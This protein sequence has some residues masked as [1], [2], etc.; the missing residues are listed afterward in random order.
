MCLKKKK[1]GRVSKEKKGKERNERR[2]EARTF[3]SK[4]GKARRRE[5]EKFRL[6]LIFIA[7]V[8]DCKFSS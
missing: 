8:N 4:K 6:A 7:V 5:E 2:Q 3:K 1:R